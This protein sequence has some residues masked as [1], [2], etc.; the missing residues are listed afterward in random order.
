MTEKNIKKIERKRVTEDRSRQSERAEAWRSKYF[1]MKEQ[2][3][4]KEKVL[5][6]T[7]DS[8]QKAN[9]KFLKLRRT[10]ENC[11]NNVPVVQQLREI[12]SD[13]ELMLIIDKLRS[14]ITDR[15][16]TITYLEDQLF[17]S[18]DRTKDLLQQEKLTRKDGK[19][20][21]PEIREASYHILDL[22]MAKENVS[23]AVRR[24]YE[25]LTGQELVGSLP[26][27]RT[28]NRFGN[29]MK[30]VS[31]QQL[32]EVL[33]DEENTTLRF[34]GSTKAGRHEVEVEIATSDKTY[35]LGIKEQEGEQQ[36]NIM[37]L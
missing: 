7:L 18:E 9:S 26:T 23:E 13:N 11:N 25:C 1:D 32:N 36:K 10:H 3:D 27:A 4:I 17:Q 24:V 5:S 6:K 37:R 14:Q 33:Q 31:Y 8:L 28:L 30:L 29:E 19:S 35:L 16:E 21:T 34:D 22:G 20:Y 2:H 12:S 15:N